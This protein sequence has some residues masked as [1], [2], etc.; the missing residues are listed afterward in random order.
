[1]MPTLSVLVRFVRLEI[2]FVKILWE[3]IGKLWSRSGGRES[4]ESR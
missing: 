4:G 3:C 1:M 2:V